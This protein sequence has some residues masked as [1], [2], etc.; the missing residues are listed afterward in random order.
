M[1]RIIRFSV[2]HPLAVLVLTFLCTAGM[3]VLIP[4]VHL[5]LDARSLVPATDPS[6]TKSDK[7]TELFKI[8]DVVMLGVVNEDS[9]IYD[10]KT[11]ALIQRLTHKLSS[12]DGVVASSVTSVATI[13]GMSITDRQIELK[14]LISS[15]A[16]ANPQDASRVRDRVE[17]LHLN[18]GIL[19]A[20]DGRAAT[21]F[22]EIRPDA[23]RFAVLDQVRNL[24]AEENQSG[25]N[26][27]LSGTA[28]AQAVLGIASAHDL[29][30]LVPLVLI[31]LFIAL[32][33]AFKNPV[34]AILSLLEIGISLLLTIGVL[35]LTGQSV[36]ITTLILP[37]ILVSVGVSDDVYA[38]KHY[39]SEVENA[40]GISR[41]ELLIKAF[42]SLTR[43]ICLT[44]LSTV[45][46]L[47][48]L[49]VTRL[50][51]LIVFGI[52]GSL[53][54]VLSTILTF[55]LIPALL[56]LLGHRAF[57]TQS[58]ALNNKPSATA[59]LLRPVLVVG[60]RRIVVVTAG[61]AILAAL[62]TTKL[63]IDDSWIR[64]LPPNSDVAVGD[65]A[66]NQTLAGSTTID[67]MVDSG[68]NHGFVE[69]QFVLALANIEDSTRTLPQVGAVH[70][71]F[72]DVLRLNASLRGMAFDA[73]RAA[74]AKNEL[75]LDRAEIEQ[76][77][78]LLIGTRR[79]S[80]DKWIDKDYRH[81]RMTVFVRS[82]D[83][84]RIAGVLHTTLNAARK[85]LGAEDKITPFGDGW[86]SYNTVRLL[87]EGQTWS[88]GLALM[89]DLLVLSVLWKSV[90]SALTAVI[91]VAFSVLIVFACLAATGVSLG[92]A[93][94][95]FAGISIGIG[96]DFA[97][98]LTDSYHRWRLLGMPP[99]VAMSRALTKVGPAVATSAMA[100][101]MGFLVLTLSQITPNAQL[102]VMICLSL[103]VCA[104]STLI[105]LPGMVLDLSSSKTN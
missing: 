50:E 104:I 71:L 75:T 78:Q 69:P 40:A 4:R 47:L 32:T 59:A 84:K 68:Q 102:G 9:G 18:D 34:P 11:L 42:G 31:V 99:E 97:I 89:T 96:M 7:A 46:G 2:S 63:T 81:V 5:K 101:T 48:S 85:S 15:R 10:P 54:I 52:F 36:F 87:V 35:G 17:S 29:A 1:G 22:G 28:L 61:I 37:V 23:N 8:R 65:K 39:F 98:H 44:T 57:R 16:A 21:I 82:A 66:L 51:P 88:I 43:P 27:Y 94:S 58:P 77:L 25:A 64:N 70:S 19:V 45:I 67:F 83:Y 6:F 62:L 14:P 86:I 103:A 20:Q 80:L 26:V 90:R 73:Y 30:R 33:I 60:P 72:N 76:S 92:I 3:C 49:T 41:Q 91:P 12:V 24:A 53:A 13:P 55:T 95:M 105:L 93:N 74:L 100:I 38:L 56:V 79:T